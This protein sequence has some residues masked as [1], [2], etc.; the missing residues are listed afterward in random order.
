[1][2]SSLR[3]IGLLLGLTAAVFVAH[4]AAAVASSHAV[5]A[6]APAPRAATAVKPAPPEPAPPKPTLAPRTP[7]PIEHRIVTVNGV[8]LPWYQLALLERLYP[9]RIG[10]GH[11]WYDRRSGFWGHWGGPTVGLILPGLPVGGPLPANASAGDTGIFVNGRELPR[12]DV[13]MLGLL[14]TEIEPGR[15]WIN[16]AGQVRREKGPVLFNM[17]TLIG[18]AGEG[19]SAPG[20]LRASAASGTAWGGCVA[21][22][23]TAPASIT[24]AASRAGRWSVSHDAHSSRRQPALRGRALRMRHQS[25]TDALAR[26][27]SALRWTAR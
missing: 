18:E 8:P 20:S 14:F 17:W 6:H 10:D 4:G 11:F 21:A 12:V 9:V 19:D 27:R 22:G 24:S 16:P 3:V 15:Y 26:H 13:E 7:K 1:M 23:Q 5:A 2:S 25:G